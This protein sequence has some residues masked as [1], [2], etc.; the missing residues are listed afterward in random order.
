MKDFKFLN[1]TKPER[2]YMSH[3]AHL[4]PAL[5]EDE[6][7]FR[8]RMSRAPV[9]AEMTL[10]LDRF[11]IDCVVRNNPDPPLELPWGTVV[12]HSVETYPDANGWT[13]ARGNA[14]V[15]VVGYPVYRTTIL[16]LPDMYQHLIE[17]ARNE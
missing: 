4:S 13:S 15:C 5:D 14:T 7:S 8:T 2:T 9:D 16:L 6:Y 12:M 11:L 1:K 3:L 10:L 17:L